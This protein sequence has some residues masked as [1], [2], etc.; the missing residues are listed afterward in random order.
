MNK[1]IYDRFFNKDV[2]KAVTNHKLNIQ[3]IDFSSESYVFFFFNKTDRFKEITI[4]N[5]KL[6]F[7]KVIIIFYLFNFLH[8]LI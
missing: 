4:E 2:I 5:S 7:P 3:N 8:S 6:N 1:Q